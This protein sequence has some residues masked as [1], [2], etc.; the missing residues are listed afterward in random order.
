MT[1]NLAFFFILVTLSIANGYM[2]KKGN[3][4]GSTTAWIN[5]AAAGFSAF[6]AILQ[7]MKYF[8]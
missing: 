4:R 8:G 1:Y 5:W 2:A 7:L 6:A 3:E